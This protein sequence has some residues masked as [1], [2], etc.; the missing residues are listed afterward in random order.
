[1]SKVFYPSEIIKFAIEKEQQSA[2][3]YQK[4]VNRA[5]NDGEKALFEKLMRDELHHK[6]FYADILSSVAEE[7]SPGAQE[8]NE[9]AAYMRQLI[10]ESRTVKLPD[11]ID[12]MPFNDILA[13]AIKREKDSVMFYLGLKQYVPADAQAKVE[14]I[15]AEESRHAAVIANLRK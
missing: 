12:T 7:K 6:Q 14:M 1:M 8:E 3:L 10:E 13:Y 11:D 9:Y 4:L 2:N 5:R 15:I